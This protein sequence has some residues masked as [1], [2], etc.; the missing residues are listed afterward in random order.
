[1]NGGNNSLGGSVWTERR[2]ALFSKQTLSNDLK[3]LHHWV[4]EGQVSVNVW[5]VFKA[6]FSLSWCKV[7]YFFL[8]GGKE[9]VSSETMP[10]VKVW[11][12]NVPHGLVHVLNAWSPYCRDILGHSRNFGCRG[13]SLKNYHLS[14]SISDLCPPWVDTVL[15]H[16]HFCHDGQ[17][18]LKCEQNNSFLFLSCSVRY[19]VTMTQS[20]SNKP[21][22]APTLCGLFW[23][24]YKIF[25]PICSAFCS[26]LHCKPD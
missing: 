26:Q 15:L 1:M 6:S 25:K 4:C 7:H 20:V 10:S 9:L 11:I 14:I 12:W 16:M 13:I 24:N 17:K 8:C 18:P 22:L 19:F 5:D 23:W 3:L 2:R 21:S